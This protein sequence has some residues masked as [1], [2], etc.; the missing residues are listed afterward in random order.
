MDHEAGMLEDIEVAARHELV[1]EPDG[2]VDSMHK[3]TVLALE[4]AR[5][6][7]VDEVEA[8]YIYTDGSME[9]DRNG[10]GLILICDLPGGEIGRIGI[11]SNAEEPFPNC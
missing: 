2:P 6:A 1:A 10:W 3:H 5:A 8:F 7:T 4:I 11:A 9:H